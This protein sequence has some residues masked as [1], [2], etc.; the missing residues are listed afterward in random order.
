MAPF[1]SVMGSI[2][3]P[4]DYD[5]SAKTIRVSSGDSQAVHTVGT[6]LVYFNGKGIELDTASRIVHD[7]IYVPVNYI[8][9]ITGRSAY[10]NQK[11]G[12]LRI[13]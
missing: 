12:V 3:M 11:T 2:D 8:E 9:L 4:Y 13:E 5:S 7:S 6:K 10:W 1:R